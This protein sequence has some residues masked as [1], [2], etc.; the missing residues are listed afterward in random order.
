MLK[1]PHGL[2]ILGAT[3]STENTIAGMVFNSHTKS[4]QYFIAASSKAPD[5][6]KEGQP[7]QR[8]KGPGEGSAL[9]IDLIDG[10]PEQ[11]LKFRRIG[12]Y[13]VLKIIEYDIEGVQQALR[14]QHLIVKDRKHSDIHCTAICLRNLGSRAAL[15]FHKNIY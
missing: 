1:K 7:L 14:L 5:D 13:P 8:P 6:S 11:T 12:F 9:L 2:R 3:L 15:R 10:Y 4:S